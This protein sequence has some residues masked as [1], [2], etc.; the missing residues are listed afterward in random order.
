MTPFIY[1][2]VGVFLVGVI[3][4]S[5]NSSCLTTRQEGNFYQNG[6]TEVN[7]TLRYWVI[8]YFLNA[9]DVLSG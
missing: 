4:K 3:A 7:R 6:F 1:R 5:T 8:R 9:G 2:V